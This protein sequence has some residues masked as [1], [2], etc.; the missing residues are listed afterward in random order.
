MNSGFKIA[1]LVVG[2]ASVVNVYAWKEITLNKTDS[3]LSLAERYH[4]ATVSRSDM[5]TAIRDANPHVFNKN[6]VF[7]TSVNIVIPS[8]ALE[9][10]QALKGKYPLPSA[11][12]P[13]KKINNTNPA[14]VNT[15][16]NAQN[17]A[18]AKAVISAK[19]TSAAN[20]S[21]MTIQSL[22]DTVSSQ[23]QAIQSY[24]TQIN[25]L[26]AQLNLA[27]QKIQDLQKPT[28]LLLQR[29]ENLGYLWLGL[30]LITLTLLLLQYYKYKNLAYDD[31]VDEHADDEHTEACIEVEAEALEEVV[32]D[33]VFVPSLTAEFE[34]DG[35]SLQI[36][37][38]TTEVSSAHHENIEAVEDQNWEQAELD[39][40]DAELP[41]AHGQ[42]NQGSIEM[43]ENHNN[44]GQQE[45]VIEALAK[46][47]DSRAW[48]QALLEFYVKTN[49]QHGFKRHYQNMIKEGLMNEGDPLWEEVRK[50]YLNKWI[51]QTI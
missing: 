41:A 35:P 33:P 16:V 23:T 39:I 34:A 27:I 43:A 20:D 21:A 15:L 2:L 17:V 50:M 12:A 28:P 32:H 19:K 9:V 24:Q 11:L 38:E 4:L 36:E 51:Y 47:E 25:Q 6:F 46:D 1:L 49:S 10:H 5:I 18:K 13:T 26:N 31:G 44:E 29:I 8:S 3:A 42:I 40:P 30:W 37:A 45:N 14:S 7:K 48:H 22:Q